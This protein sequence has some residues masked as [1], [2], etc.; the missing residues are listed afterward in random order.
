MKAEDKNLLDETAKKKVE[1][2]DNKQ[3]VVAD[4]KK[5]TEKKEKKPKEVIFTLRKGMIWK[6]AIAGKPDFQG[7][8]K[9][10]G[11]RYITVSVKDKEL[12]TKCLIGVKIGLLMVVKP[13]EKE[14]SEPKINSAAT[15]KSG[16][17]IRT[18]S[19]TLNT[20]MTEFLI[21]NP[22]MEKLIKKINK[23]NDL[24]ELEVI[25]ELEKRGQNPNGVVRNPILDAIQNRILTIHSKHP[26]YSKNRN[27]IPDRVPN[28]Q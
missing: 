23:M 6:P 1:K 22:D 5:N 15:Y 26:Y 2:K 4:A 28:T 17:K 11:I 20:K 14:T 3:K 18:K 12:Y 16:V 25:I 13:E 24:T 21:A 19:K 7:I 9:L 8:N 27:T 10:A